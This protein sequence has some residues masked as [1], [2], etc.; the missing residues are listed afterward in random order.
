MSNEATLDLIVD[1]VG[2]Q[3][4]THSLFPLWMELTRQATNTDM[5]VMK[6]ERKEMHLARKSHI[7]LLHV[8]I[9]LID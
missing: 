8:S 3:Y 5:T 7:G 4:S 1:L 2:I 9:T 6:T